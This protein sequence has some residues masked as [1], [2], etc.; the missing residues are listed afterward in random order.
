MGHSTFTALAMALLFSIALGVIMYFQQKDVMFSA[1]SFGVSLIVLF[2]LY[3]GIL[4]H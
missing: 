4:R 2:F 3:F 1:I